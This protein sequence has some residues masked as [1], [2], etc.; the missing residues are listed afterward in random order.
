MMTV[1]H[2]WQRAT[3]CHPRRS[4]Q[5]TRPISIYKVSPVSTDNSKQSGREH[6]PLGNVTQHLD[7]AFAD[8]G[9]GAALKPISDVPELLYCF[10][11]WPASRQGS[12]DGPSAL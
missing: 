10:S 1:E 7:R 3:A 4:R 9:I 12:L 2:Q 6:W 11:K 5:N 8:L